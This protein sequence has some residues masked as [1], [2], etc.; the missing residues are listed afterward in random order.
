MRNNGSVH[1]TYLFDSRGR[2]AGRR[3]DPD[4]DFRIADPHPSLDTDPCDYAVELIG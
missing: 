2:P 4:L 3:M 1:G